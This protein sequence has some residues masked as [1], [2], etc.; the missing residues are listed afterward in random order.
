MH[1]DAPDLDAQLRS[2]IRGQWQQAPALRDDL[3]RR[4]A[5]QIA[6]STEFYERIYE[7]VEARG[8]SARGTNGTFARRCERTGRSHYSLQ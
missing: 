1:L 6:R 7:M 3:R 5:D 8:I 4:A 2:G